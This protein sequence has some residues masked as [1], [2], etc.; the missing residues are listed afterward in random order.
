MSVDMASTV[1]YH[2]DAVCRKFTGKERDSESG[3]DH[4]WFRQYSS[5]LGRWMHPDPAGLAAVDPANPQS[6][7]R[8]SYV[9]NSPTNLVDPLGLVCSG[10]AGDQD[11]PCNPANSG[12]GGGSGSFGGY[13]EFFLMF[14]NPIPEQVLVGWGVI[15]FQNGMSVLGGCDGPDCF[16]N[17]F[18]IYDTIYSYPFLGLGLYQAIVVT[19]GNTDMAKELARAINATGVQTL[20][21]PCTPAAFY[22]LSV[23]GGLVTDVAAG[24]E[25]LTVANEALAPHLPLVYRLLRNPLVSKAG[26]LVLK[27]AEKAG[28]AI[29]SGCNAMQ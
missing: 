18:P 9:L 7:N 15:G 20:A 8:Y 14:G 1:T 16:N 10:N 11:T 13:G 24:G 29:Q 22:A 6:W 28:S 17:E 5:S 27:G 21:N 3:L 2:Y 26:M 23:G 4:T 25:A 12:G 19:P